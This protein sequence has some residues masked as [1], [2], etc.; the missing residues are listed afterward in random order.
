LNVKEADEE[1]VEQRKFEYE[2]LR[3][4]NEF[5]VLLDFYFEKRM[6]CQGLQEEQWCEYLHPKNASLIP[7]LE[8]IER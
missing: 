8:R 1:V 2:V 4:K 3:D 7:N 5:A 6:L